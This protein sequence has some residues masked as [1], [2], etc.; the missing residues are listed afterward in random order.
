MNQ[1]ET[2][3]GEPQSSEQ[4]QL[5][6]DGDSMGWLP[7][8]EPGSQ[9]GGGPHPEPRTPLDPGPESSSSLAETVGSPAL[10]FPSEP[11]ARTEQFP[12]ARLWALAA[13][14]ATVVI[15]SLWPSA[16]SLAVEVRDELG[17]RLVEGHV[18]IIVA[19]ARESGVEP[20]LLA[21]IMFV[22][23]HGRGGQTSSAGALGLM[24]LVPASAGDAARRLDLPT[25]TTEQLL[26]DDELNV[27]LGAAHLAWLLQHRGDWSLEQV[28]VSY[29]AGRVKLMRW[30]DRH[31]G[32]T[33]WR[34]QEEREELAGGRTTGAL[35]YALEVLEARDHLLER[36]VIPGPAA[37]H[38]D[39]E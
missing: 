20:S 34:A 31:G 22:E 24:Q 10:P 17:L 8:A 33:G 15:W 9:A 13:L 27:R 11:P 29:N 32:Y 6:H 21:G 19:A 12:R 25:P 5:P 16:R 4:Q 30:M 23:S 38:P 39:S 14:M 37:V 18:E 36:G 26:E 28:L 7:F 3:P 1:R 35:R 2:P